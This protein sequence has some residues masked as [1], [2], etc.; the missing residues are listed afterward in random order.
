MTKKELIAAVAARTNMPKCAAEEAIDA[1]FDAIKET[2]ISH[3]DVYVPGFGKFQAAY[4]APRTARN[5]QSGDM[6]DVPAK[7]A[8]KFT[9]ASD[10]KRS[11]K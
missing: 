10:L 2:L 5:P 11:V 4:R 8:V 6:M 7:F 3:E 1:V 9:P